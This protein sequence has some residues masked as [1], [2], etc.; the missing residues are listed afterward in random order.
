MNQLSVLPNIPHSLPYFT[1]RLFRI[2]SVSVLSVS[3]LSDIHSIY[4]AQEKGISDAPN[5]SFQ[6]HTGFEVVDQFAISARVAHKI[7]RLVFLQS[8]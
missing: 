4:L 2:I 5:E 1:K 8:E 6:I 3:V 7:P